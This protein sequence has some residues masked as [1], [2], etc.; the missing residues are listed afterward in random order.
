MLSED[1]NSSLENIL[2]KVVSKKIYITSVSYKFTG[3]AIES[4]IFFSM[5]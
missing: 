4:I 1:T 2:K 5:I 3:F